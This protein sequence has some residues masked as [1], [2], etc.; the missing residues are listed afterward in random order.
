M[1]NR[2][3]SPVIATLLLLVIAVSAA[4]FILYLSSSAVL[5]R[6][7][8]AE[9]A[10]IME[11]L[12]IVQVKVDLDRTV[13]IWVVNRG[14]VGAMMDRLYVS[15]F[16]GGM[17]AVLPVDT[18]LDPGQMKDIIVDAAGY[19]VWKWYEITG[20]TDRGNKVPSKISE[21]PF[22]NLAFPG[23]GPYE[24]EYVFRVT[25]I[26]ANGLP[27]ASPETLAKVLSIDGN[28]YSVGSRPGTFIG[29]NASVSTSYYELNGESLEGPKKV[30]EDAL[31]YIDGKI[32][33]VVSNKL[34]D[35][36]LSSVIFEGKVQNPEFDRFML[37]FSATIQNGNFPVNVTVEF[38]EW[39]EG[40]YIR[41]GNGYWYQSFDNSAMAG[42]YTLSTGRIWSK[43]IFSDAGDWKV[44][45]NISAAT[46]GNLNTKYD[47]L[48]L[49]LGQKYYEG[50]EVIL[51]FDTSNNAYNRENVTQML[52]SMTG[53]FP[54]A[55][56]SYWIDIFNYSHSS[57]GAKH[58]QIIGILNGGESPQTF[59]KTLPTASSQDFIG[60]DKNVMIRIHPVD[61][62]PPE[63]YI[64]I[65]QAK[66]IITVA[67]GP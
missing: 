1:N 37:N 4:A 43:G 27:E 36:S 61:N 24:V 15:D 59:I 14:G 8:E 10:R 51:S 66:L 32:I 31:Y 63:T 28:V 40:S 33:H 56:S 50:L 6:S 35:S 58:W 49:I 64:Q 26:I 55:R 62:L 18:A 16:N 9:G 20:V 12:K 7:S 42:N 46:T 52:F 17:A 11:D 13:H 45:I 65:D 47:Y 34:A 57:P 38:W 3:L 54:P 29:Y 19:E 25:K 41:S 48:S 53:T 5:S 67:E 44:R 22:T 30:P 2:G 60:S 21:N 39:S 23:P